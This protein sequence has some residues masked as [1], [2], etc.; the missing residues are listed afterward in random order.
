M[1]KALPPASNPGAGFP[2]GLVAQIVLLVIN[3][4]EEIVE[5][6]K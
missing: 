4:I 5:D 3:I 2:W 1:T 6:K